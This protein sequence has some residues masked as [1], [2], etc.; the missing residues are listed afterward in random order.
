MM[1]R[2]PDAE[3]ILAVL[4][5]KCGGKIEISARE[6]QEVMMR[7][8]MHMGGLE[9]YIVRDP[10]LIVLKLNDPGAPIQETATVVDVLALPNQSQPLKD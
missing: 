8:R 9:T 3:D 4:V 6:Y 2:M 5:A 10:H 7:L 1:D